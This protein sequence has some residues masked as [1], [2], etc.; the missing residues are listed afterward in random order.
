M[1]KLRNGSQVKLTM[2]LLTLYLTLIQ[3]ELKFGRHK[4]SVQ[5]LTVP[6]IAISL[7]LPNLHKVVTSFKNKG[8]HLADEMLDV[9]WD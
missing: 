4:Y 5:L 7:K 2:G 6:T 8:F 1:G 3:A 9:S